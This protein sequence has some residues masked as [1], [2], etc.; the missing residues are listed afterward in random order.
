TRCGEPKWKKT[1]DMRIED[2]W[3]QLEAEAR[4][5][6]ASAWLTRFALPQPTQPLLVALETSCNRR[7]LLLQLPKAAIPARRLWP[8][9][10]GLE[11]FSAVIGGQPHLGVRLLVP[12]FADVFAAL[13]EDVA[14][15]V[16]A[17]AQPKAAS[18]ALLSRLERWQK[19]LAAG[20]MGLSVE[21]W[22][23]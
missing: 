20:K 3:R 14:P 16:A 7:A 15:R 19:F 5:G 18:A 21:R 6:T 10:R 13:A 12:L 4:A 17:A 22:R 9:C 23:G 8:Q 1:K 2:V 11:I